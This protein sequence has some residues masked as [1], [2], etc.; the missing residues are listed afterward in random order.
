[1]DSLKKDFIHNSFLREREREEERE[2]GK[3]SMREKHLL[4]K[5]GIEPATFAFVE[6][7]PTDRATPVRAIWVF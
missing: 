2:G 4:G 6:Q 1:M 5:P 3:I 7:C